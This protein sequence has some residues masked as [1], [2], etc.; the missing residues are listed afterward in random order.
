MKIL[1]VGGH[2]ALA[3][4]LSLVLASLG[5]A[6]TAGRSGC[7]ETLAL[8]HATI[9]S[10]IRHF[11][12][13]SSINAYLDS[14][15]A[16]YGAYSLSKR[17]GDELVQLYCSRAGLPCAILQPSQLYG[18]P[19]SFRRNQ[20]FVYDTLDKTLLDEAIVIYRSRD[21][22]RNYLHAQDFCRISS[23][24]VGLYASTTAQDSSLLAVS[25]T[26]VKTA[27]SAGKV[28]FNRAMNDIADSVFPY[29]DTLYR[30]IGTYPEIDLNDGMGRLVANRLIMS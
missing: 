16:F 1:I 25:S 29:D 13:I 15:S 27:G 8:C 23:R 2:C 26:I 19:D 6:L 10:G 17:H 24:V 7:D 22:Q 3:Q 28:V 30:S 21:A 20:P 9:E 5:E 11:V 18:E 4:I 14:D 12:N